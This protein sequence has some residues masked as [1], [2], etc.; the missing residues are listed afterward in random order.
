MDTAGRAQV[1][2][3]WDKNTLTARGTLVD[4][5]RKVT[6]APEVH[7]RF[8]LC[9]WISA[10]FYV[11]T[12]GFLVFKVQSSRWIIIN[13][14]REA[15]REGKRKEMRPR[16]RPRPTWMFSENAQSSRVKNHVL[17]G[18]RVWPRREG[19]APLKSALKSNFIIQNKGDKPGGKGSGH[20]RETST[21]CESSGSAQHEHV[22]EAAATGWLPEH[23]RS[24]WCQSLRERAVSIAVPAARHTC[25]HPA[26]KLMCKNVG[27]RL[28]CKLQL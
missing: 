24:L 28:H 2:R 14:G 1:T 3:C 12:A 22:G 6:F 9:V 20:D 8:I 16:R 25:C 11:P 15:L 7:T 18:S 17:R 23:Q 13:A 5:A 26:G 21:P 27:N 19:V 4:W 10:A